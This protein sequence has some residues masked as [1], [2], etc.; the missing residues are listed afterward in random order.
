MTLRDSTVSPLPGGDVLVRAEA[1]VVYAIDDAA[2]DAVLNEV[3]EAVATAGASHAAPGRRLLRRLAGLVSQA[4]PEEV[5]SFAAAADTEDGIAVMVVGDVDVRVADAGG[6]QVLSGRSAATW[7]DRI[8]DGTVLTLT[9][10]RAAHAAA[11]PDRWADLQAGC[12]PAGGV[13][14]TTPGGDLPSP[15]AEQSRD[16]AAEPVVGAVDEPTTAIAQPPPGGAPAAVPPPVA[17]AQRSNAGAAF[18]SV[19]LLDV[20]PPAP[21]QPLPV[22]ADDR[23]EEGDRVQV[24]GIHCARRHFNDP[25][26]PYCAVCGI[27]MVQQTHDLVRGPRPPLGVLVLDDGSTFGVDTDYVV[28]REPEGDAGVVDGKMLPLTLDDPARSVSRVHARILL[29]GW[30][31]RLADAGSANGT[32]LALPGAPDWQRLDPDDARTLRP[33]SRIRLGQRELVFDS[34]HRV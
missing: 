11:A 22:A 29:D 12:V 24:E 31:V 19:S 14:V 34:H 25:R 10:L 1:I 30:D 2:T 7:I 6:E 26:A 8:L 21:P 15:M 27:S 33:G 4:D 5:P 9:M 32:Y 13:V 23:A 18:T 16:V 28:G 20:E 17:T 3:L